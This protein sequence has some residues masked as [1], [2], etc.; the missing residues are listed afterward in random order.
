MRILITR[1]DHDIVTNYLSSWSKELIELAENNNFKVFDLKSDE[2]NKQN[3]ESYMRKQ[4]VDLVLLNGHGNENV[5]TGF[6]NE[7]I[8]EANINEDILKDCVVHALS[9]ESSAVLGKKAVE[10]GAKAYFGY[11]YPFTFVTEKNNECRP[12]QDK[13]ANLFKNPALE[14]PK[15]LI[16]GKEIR[17]SYEKGIEKYKQALMLKSISLTEEESK[18][19]RFALF[20]D[21]KGLSLNVK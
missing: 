1:P 9:C 3:F 11:K 10:S 12:S 6:K 17:E 4:N 18:S 13:F 15:C 14:V 19:V 20:W 5:V 7:P 21:M 16:S 8:V 2:A